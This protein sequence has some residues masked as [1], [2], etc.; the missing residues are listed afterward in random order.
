MPFNE[1][2]FWFGIT[3][4]GTGLYFWVEGT[5][6]RLHSISLTVIGALACAYSVYRHYH[7]EFPVIRVWVILLMLT[8][9]LL[10]YSIYLGKFR[11][12]SPTEKLKEPSKLVI[13]SANYAAW[14]GRGARRDVTKFLRSI[15]N[16][17]SL[18]FGPIENHSFVVN[19]ENLVPQDPMVG[20]PKR[21][22][23]TYSYD[24]EKPK[25]I[26]RAEHGRLVLPEDST[27][28]WQEKQIEQL[29]A[30]Q[31]KPVQYPV[32]QLRMKIIETVS[33]LQGF[34]GEHGN[35]PDEVAR[36]G[37]STKDTVFRYLTEGDPWKA[38][39]IGDYRLR[40]GDSIPKLR[41]EMRVRTSISDSEL[42]RLIEA[43]A[44]NEEDS[45]MAVK[46]IIDR[47]WTLGRNVNA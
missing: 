19:G 16:G 21:L 47:L 2:L 46:G 1:A 39:F 31:P 3:G 32:P 13:D 15:I 33:A 24:G 30:A 20:D 37:E 43:A 23:L 40:F 29:K 14:S 45:C 5:V 4:F 41:D 12:L 42:N 11:R 36:P 27:I 44:N 35:E 25:T 6:K 38:K 9:A 7:P 17:D 18:V 34:L 10:G 28:E 22:E 26:R 8:W